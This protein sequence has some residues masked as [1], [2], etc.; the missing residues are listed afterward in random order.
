MPGLFERFIA[1]YNA[2]IADESRP[3]DGV[4]ETLEQDLYF[5]RD[6]G[7]F[8]RALA[9]FQGLGGTLANV[10]EAEASSH[11]FEREWAEEQL[12]IAFKLGR[13]FELD[14]EGEELAEC[15]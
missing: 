1:R 3:F 7:D 9:V 12:A 4:I 13:T 2:H 14:E 8:F 5:G 11:T 10:H 6:K 15:E